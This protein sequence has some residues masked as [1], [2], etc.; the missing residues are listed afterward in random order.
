MV[1]LQCDEFSG[2]GAN[3]VVQRMNQF[4][5][6]FVGLATLISCL[7]V[8]ALTFS[9]FH[10]TNS[11][12]VE[13]SEGCLCSSVITAVIAAVAATM[14][15][16]QFDGPKR[17]TGFELA[18]AWAPLTLLDLAIVEFLVGMACWYFGKNP[19][20]GG[21]FVTTYTSVL[22]SFCF[23]VSA[24]MFGKWQIRGQCIKAQWKGSPSPLLQ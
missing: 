6:L 4:Y 1:A 2:T 12:F 16:F 7:A 3:S 22:L 14:L 21:V 15:L 17:I 11:R 20:R 23:I 13:L 9:E 19:G 24:W 8:G 5:K 10:P 18:V